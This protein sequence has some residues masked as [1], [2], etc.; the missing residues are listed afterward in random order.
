MF[1]RRQQPLLPTS[2]FITRQIKHILI[3]FAV[4]GGSLTIGIVGYH[5]F[6]ELNWIDAFVNASM[7]LAGMGPT[8][9][10]KTDIAKIFAGCYALFSGLIFIVSVGILFAPLAHRM[11]H[12]FHLEMEGEGDSVDAG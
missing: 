1:E 8:D 3:T 5:F 9:P 4:I 7:I 2:Q 6:A 12:Y 11:F 10:L